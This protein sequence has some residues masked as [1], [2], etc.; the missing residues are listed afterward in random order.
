V[1]QCNWLDGR[2]GRLEGTTDASGQF[3]IGTPPGQC[4]LV[5][6]APQGLSFQGPRLRLFEFAPGETV[7]ITRRLETYPAA[8]FIEGRVLDDGGQAVSGARVILRSYI[9][10]AGARQWTVESYRPPAV[11]DATGSFRL[12]SGRPGTYEIVVP[13][14]GLSRLVEV[15]GSTSTPVPPVAVIVR[16]ARVPAF[17]V[18]GRVETPAGRSPSFAAVF[19]DRGDSPLTTPMTIAQT[20]AD[21]TGAFTFA[22]VPAGPYRVRIDTSPTMPAGVG[23]APTEIFWGVTPVVVTGDVS[24]VVLTARPGPE[25]RA[26]VRLDDQSGDRNPNQRILLAI[27]AAGGRF[28]PT[29]LAP[30]GVLATRGL[31]PERYRIRASGIPTGYRV[32]SVTAGGRDVTVEGFNLADGPIGDMVITLT[33]QLTEVKGV[34]RDAQDRPDGEAAVLAF[35][36]DR[37]LWTETGQIPIFIQDVHVS[38]K[39]NYSVKSLPAG[40]YFI[41]ATFSDTFLTTDAETL[42]RFAAGA[43]R[44]R[45][46]DGQVVTINLRTQK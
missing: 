44:I 42:E 35:P 4:T 14:L 1:L 7:E 15:T 22:D 39:G 38:Q 19:L 17:R 24:G 40:E 25:L 30:D 5:V 26:E 6:N 33:K 11:T 23:N 43:E 13:A 31:W 45:L 12:G 2:W 18:S 36:T 27:D 9:I 3:T 16:G 20:S 34:V 28:V 10:R 29:T 46:T 21:T 37:R 8:Q 32:K 41:V